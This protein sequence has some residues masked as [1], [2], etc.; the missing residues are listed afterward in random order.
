MS[1]EKADRLLARL[2]RLENELLPVMQTQLDAFGQ[3]LR[4]LGLEVHEMR[5][6]VAIDLTDDIKSRPTEAV[7]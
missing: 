6:E 1:D 2:D 4:K 5:Q 7:Q 3:T